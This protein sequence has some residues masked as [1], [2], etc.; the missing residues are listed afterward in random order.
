MEELFGKLEKQEA[1]IGV[2]GLGYVG[3]PLACLLAEK[4]SVV[5]FDIN[6]TRV[7]ELRDGIDRTKEIEDH[8][9]LT[10]PNIKFTCEQ[11]ALKECPLIIVAVPT[12]ITTFKVPDLNPLISASRTVGKTISAGS[13][14]VFESTVYPGL[15]ESVCGKCIEE[16]SGLKSGKDFYLGYSP[17]RV[18]PGDKLHT[19][20]K[21][22][23]VVSGQTPEVLKLL[24]SV[25]GAVISAGIHEAPSI[26]TAEAAKVIENTQRDLNIALVNELSMLFERIG[27]DTLDVLTAASTKWNFLNF[28]PGLVGGHCIGVDPYYLTHLADGVGFHP[29]V[30][31]AGRRINDGMGK[32]VAEKT[33][34]LCLNNEKHSSRQLV[35]GILGVTFK[36]NVPDL[37]NSKVLD[38]VEVLESF[39]V[40]VYLIDPVAN[41]HEFKE[42]YGR[43]LVEWDLMPTCD[44][45]ILA[46]QHDY[47]KTNYSLEKL[48]QKLNGKKVIVD[49]KGM[50]SRDEA[51]ENGVQLWRP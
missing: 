9:R 5:G 2:V 6:E 12:P 43:D 22:V 24:S 45:L 44:A 33:I 21:I 51:T 48:S 15:T 40:K 38:V 36:E 3:L 13:V 37:R 49:I 46:V 30:I 26:A 14:V 16:T 25:Y 1:K 27:L 42:E 32:F 23:K 19:I 31:M 8:G 7:A 20:D 35:V 10:N 47:F 4:F 11:E 18:N 50:L 29:Q 34:R 17:E 39:G 41:G 28:R